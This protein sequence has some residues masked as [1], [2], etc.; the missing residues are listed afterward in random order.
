MV[1]VVAIIAIVV[2][3]YLVLD[4]T[5]ASAQSSGTTRQISIAI[6]VAEG[7]YD[8]SGN[9]LNNGTLPSRNHNPG[10][11]TVD[12]NSTGSGV[13]GGFVVYPDDAT[14]FAA[15]D[16]QVGKWLDG[17][18]DNATAAST[19]A[20]I[21]QFY[22]TTDQAAWAANVA[23]V[24]GVTV[25]TSLA[26]IVGGAAPATPVSTSTD[27]TQIADTSGDD[28]DADNGSQDDGSAQDV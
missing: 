23:S 15:L 10:D 18:S 4:A 5:G 2:V 7:G 26:T 21:S 13:S 19:I 16:Y 9:N 20:Q 24:L 14:G 8:A 25:D 28:S 6:G 22:T 17:S 27:P 11:L 1:A 12:V 3:G